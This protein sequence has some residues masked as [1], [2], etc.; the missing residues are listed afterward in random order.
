MGV[1]LT[2]KWSAEL[3]DIEKEMIEQQLI[4]LIKANML[5]QQEKRFS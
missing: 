1:F 2:H 4:I 5:I 3:N